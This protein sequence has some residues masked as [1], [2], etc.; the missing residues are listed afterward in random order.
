MESLIKKLFLCFV[1]VSVS[2]SCSDA[3]VGDV[4]TETEVWDEIC[5][6]S[7]LASGLGSE[8]EG[9]AFN[10]DPIVS[11]GN[12]SL[13]PLSST[14]GSGASSVSLSNLSGQGILKGTF[15][16]IRNYNDCLGDYGAYNEKNEFYY[17]HGEAGF[18][19]V[20]CY[21]YGN[22]L[23]SFQK[24]S[25]AFT[26]IKALKIFAHC[27]TNDDAYYWRYKNSAGAIEEEVCIGDS[28]LTP[29]A[30]YAD[31]A[32]VLMHEVQHASTVNAY[33][34]VNSLNR[35]WYDEAGALNEGISDFMAMM[36]SEPTTLILDP[37]I[38]SRWALGT[39]FSDREARGAHRCPEYDADYPNCSAYQVGA[40]G[41]SAGSP[42]TDV[43]VSYSYPD[44][45]G[46]LYS[47][48]SDFAPG[49]LKS[50]YTATIQEIIHTSGV[51]ISGTLW[52]LYEAIKENENGNSNAAQ[53]K[54]SRLIHEALRHLPKPSWSI[55]SPVTFMGFAQML[56]D[57]A[58]IV[59]LTEADR[60]DLAQTLENRGLYNINTLPS[61]WAS[62]GTGEM[63]TAGISVI[64]NPT[65][66]K[67]WIGN[68]G[69]NQ[70]IVTQSSGNYQLEAGDVA[71]IWFDIKNT[72]TLTAGGL[73]IKATSSSSDVTFLDYTYNAGAVSENEVQFFYS[74]INGTDIV[75]SLTSTDPAYNVPTSNSYFT[76]HP[77]YS[78][79]WYTAVWIKV[80][81]G[82][83]PQVIN[84]EL[85]ITP[86]NGATETVNFPLTIN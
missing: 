14:I 68:F 17:A 31:D 53:L 86:S 40:A 7:T 12:I 47:L 75:N 24:E 13:S 74:K 19:E 52:D 37:R 71:A 77:N 2:V 21:H 63:E 56:V 35:Y 20:M 72:S 3:P 32:M 45:L 8:G 33:S 23:R 22:R 64:D 82:T 42:D 43:K 50:Y 70:N 27:G 1:F 28:K 58:E 29:G 57:Y 25:Y 81:T 10:I 60:T 73:H 76:T 9:S 79:T 41:F 48:K 11:S 61:G 62:V 84:L 54:V 49:Y 4:P 69:A 39:F 16:D 67:N 15:V 78:Y 46:W 55:L 44:G 38:F 36:F 85:E 30:S 59:G 34:L 83:T 5:A 6:P 51:L 65:I 18:Q 66:L 80:A 26:E